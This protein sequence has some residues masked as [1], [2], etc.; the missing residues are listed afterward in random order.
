[1]KPAG[2]LWINRRRGILVAMAAVVLLAFMVLLGRDAILLRLVESVAKDRVAAD[3]SAQL[4]DGL[5]VGLCGAGSPM[6]D[7]RR[8]GPCTVVVA[9]SKTLVFDAGSGSARN[10]SRMGFFVARVDAVF[11]THFHSDHIDGLGELLMQRW[12]SG[13]HSEPPVVYGPNGVDRVLAGFMQAYAMDQRHRV[14]HHGE[15]T[16]PSSGFGARAQTFELPQAGRVPVMRTE[17]LLVEA[18]AVDHAPVRPAVGYR[19]QYKGRTAVISGDTV[20]S[21]AVREAAQGV[22]LLVHDAMAPHLV[23]LI[24]RAAESLGRTTLKQLMA[25]ITDYHASTTDAAETAREA[26]VRYLLLT[27]IAPPL[28]LPG[29]ESLF[30]NGADQVYPGPIRVGRDGDLITMPAAVP[31]IS[32]RR[33]F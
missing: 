20:R 26:G 24:E 32:H 9:G 19:I 28:P 30:L 17:D 29:M 23:R 3:R 6:P 18:F 13:G 21:D 2:R 12:V 27:H 31:D 22:D 4:P 7:P 1:M 33:L 25:D 16:L 14:D 15:S 10:L 5:H 11:L 8:M